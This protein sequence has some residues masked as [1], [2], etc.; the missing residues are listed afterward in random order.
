MPVIPTQTTISE[1]NKIT[2][3]WSDHK[4][5]VL[6][7]Q[8]VHALCRDNYELGLWTVVKMIAGE[9]GV[10]TLETPDLAALAMQ[11]TGKCHLSRAFLLTAGLLDGQ[12]YREAG[13]PRAVWHLSI[14]DLWPQNTR[15]RVTYNKLKDR[16]AWKYA[17]RQRKKL[18]HQV[19]GN[20]LR[21]PGE[22]YPPPHESYPS[23]GERKKNLLD[24]KEEQRIQTW[25]NV[26]AEL[27]LVVSRTIYDNWLRN[28]HLVNLAPGNGR[29]A[30]VIECPTPYCQDWCEHRLD[31][32]IRRTLAGIAQLDAS[33]LVI[34]YTVKGDH[35]GKIP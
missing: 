13:Y 11:S 2:P 17:Q 28:I 34:T 12:L 31:P 7:P 25:N 27:R 18:I 32:L 21:S 22:L 19:N 29:S 5:F 10:C 15:W 30:A 26:Q 24:P 3:D 16:I 35:S 4:Y 23:P 8:I 9:T 1:C 14:P 20:I 6:T 33:S